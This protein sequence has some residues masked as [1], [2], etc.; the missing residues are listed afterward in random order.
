MRDNLIEAMG[1]IRVSMSHINNLE[2]ELEV[3]KVALGEKS[4]Q[5]DQE[6]KKKI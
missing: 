6:I 3:T 4:E 2:K 1:L 5:L